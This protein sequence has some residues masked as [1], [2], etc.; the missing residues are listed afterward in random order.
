MAD[1]L[2]SAAASLLGRLTADLA[3]TASEAVAKEI[4]IFNTPSR[5]KSIS[6]KLAG[7]EMVKTIK[8][9]DKP[10]KRS[11]FYVTPLF[12][13]IEAKIFEAKTVDDFGHGEHPLIEGIAGQ[14][15]SIFM[16]Q[17]CIE[18]LK[19]VS[20]LPILIGAS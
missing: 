20:R 8:N 18:E 3:K 13:D 5:I 7:L 14:G 9:P 4:E 11:S 19:L 17:L 2:V 15:K 1:P 12:E 16:R 10:S 6:R